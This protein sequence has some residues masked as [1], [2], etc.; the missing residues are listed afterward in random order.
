MAITISAKVIAS[1]TKYFE[2]LELKTVSSAPKALTTFSLEVLYFCCKVNSE[3]DMNKNLLVKLNQ[4]QSV[5]V[6]E[7]GCGEE[8]IVELNPLIDD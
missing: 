1:L 5:S 7:E 8:V 3:Y 6:Q 2:F 4:V